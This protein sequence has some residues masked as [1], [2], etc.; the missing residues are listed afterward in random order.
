MTININNNQVFLSEYTQV[1]ANSQANVSVI[2]ENLSNEQ[3]GTVEY[4]NGSMLHIR[5]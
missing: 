2:A 1:S 3:N 4:K 5:V